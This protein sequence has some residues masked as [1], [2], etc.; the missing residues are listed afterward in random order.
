MHPLQAFYEEGRKADEERYDKRMMEDAEHARR[1]EENAR[2]L[3][4][5][6]ESK[7][8]QVRNAWFEDGELVVEQ[9]PDESVIDTANGKA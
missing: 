3:H 8:D 6:L 2:V 9:L 1:N 7:P 5:H 4:E